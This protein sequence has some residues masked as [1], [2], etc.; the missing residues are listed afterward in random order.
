MLQNGPDTFLINENSNDENISTFDSFVSD[1]ERISLNQEIRYVNRQNCNTFFIFRDNVCKYS[2]LSAK[3]IGLMR[4]NPE[5]KS[6]LGQ[7][8]IEFLGNTANPTIY[9]PFDLKSRLTKLNNSRLGSCSNI[10]SNIATPIHVSQNPNKEDYSPQHRLR[11][12]KDSGLL[13]IENKIKEIYDAVITLKMI[14]MIA[15][16]MTA[17]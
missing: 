11:T 2:R 5:N 3:D 15:R 6:M 10:P 13:E 14:I 16:I 9:F 4:R 1:L 17:L 12:Y 7:L 8:N